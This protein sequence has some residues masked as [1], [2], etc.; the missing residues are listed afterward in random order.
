[1]SALTPTQSTVVGPRYKWV[2]LSNTTV[3]VLLATINATSLMIALPV[4]F[5]GIHLDP[6]QT[7]NFPYLLWIMMGYMLVSA[8]VVVTVG[9]IGDMF[10][11]VKMYNLGFAWFTVG[12]IL[13]SLVWSTGSTG[14][15]E[16]VILRMF[17]AIG[18]ALL[19]ANSAAIITDAFPQEELGLALGINM[20]AAIF[21][22]FLGI[23]VGGLLSQLGWRWV[24]LANVPV[25]VFGTIWAYMKLKEI[26]VR[27]KAKIDWLG[28]L[29]FAAALAMILTGATYGIKPYGHS[30]TGWGNPFVLEMMFGGLA[31]LV[32]F[33][34]VEMRVDDPM[35]RLSLFRIQAF[36]AGNAASFL[37]SIGRGGFQFMLMIWFQ[38][39]WLPQHGYSFARTPLWAGIYMIP[40][41]VGF[42]VSG[43]I[44]GRLSDKYG[45]RPFATGGMLLS[46]AMYAAMMAFPAN[47]SYWPFAAVMF[48][49]GIGGG[50][51]A[52]PNTASIMNSVPARHRGAASG[53]RVTFAQSGMPLSMGL[54]FTLLVIGLNAKVP[55]AMDRGLLAHGVS[56]AAA[57]QLSHMPPLG[58]M[59]AAFLG[60]NPLKSLLGPKVLAHLTPAQTATIT[61]RSFFP[62][63]IG[64]PFKDALLLILAF[65]VAMSVIAAIAS[66]LRGEKYIYVDEESIAQKAALRHDGHRIHPDDNGRAVPDPVGDAAEPD[67]AKPSPEEPLAPAL[68]RR[69]APATRR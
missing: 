50:L 37:G 48:V 10:G 19:M 49:Q 52:A 21:G 31:C 12:A 14:A 20:V 6:L 60:I 34:V 69:T 65:A 61:G 11:R 15:L 7:A 36:T 39:I 29:S 25:G 4:I 55:S 41:M 63:L 18:G 46:G 47:F 45:A 13:L 22:S 1:M 58:Y 17:Q 16:L 38:G 30:L 53:M 68:P 3:G 26:G 35:F 67:E 43:P 8:A 57:T 56:P 33:V 5:R 9:R 28:N 2:V 64:P 66:A 23:L 24:F 42:V 51:F 54:F 44:S 40:F 27:I 32:I 59:F 62:H